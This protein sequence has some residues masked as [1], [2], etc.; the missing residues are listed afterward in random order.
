VRKDLGILDVERGALQQLLAQIASGRVSPRELA[1]YPSFLKSPAINELLTQLTQLETQ[2]TLL[3]ER[4]RE[5]DDSV[6]A[7]SRSIAAI[8]TQLTTLGGAYR[9][10][11]DR[12]RT[13][14]TSQ[15]DT[16]STVL[17]TFPGTMESSGRLVRRVVQLT[18]HHTALQA[19]LVEARLAAIGEGGDVRQLDAATPPKEVAFPRPITTLGLGVGGGAFLGLIF[20]LLAGLMGRWIDDPQAIERTTGVPALRMDGG[21]PLLMSGQP[22]SNTLLLVPLDGRTST[23]GVAERLARTALARALEPTVLDLSRQSLSAASGNGAGNGHDG[24]ALLTDVGST[25]RRL[26]G[27]FQTVIVRLPGLAS[28]ETAAALNHE[29]PVLLVAPPGRVDRR[30]LL[31]AIQTLRRLDVP[32][33]GVVVNRTSDVVVRR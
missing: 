2:R 22:V 8:D 4:R 13:D 18:Q 7:L 1:A 33:A 19:Q 30:S 17:G 29:R 3:L 14:L 23:A 6:M 28:D 26:E 32:C 21:V 31:G 10:S 20:A 12:Q 27:E 25:I 11:L 5:N 16:I 15:L 24:A 9:S